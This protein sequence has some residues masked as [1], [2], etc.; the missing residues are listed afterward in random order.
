M[1]PPPS[2][3][4]G[5][6]STPPEPSSPVME[7]TQTLDV[8]FNRRTSI[9]ASGEQMLPCGFNELG[10][11]QVIVCNRLPIRLYVYCVPQRIGCAGQIG[12]AREEE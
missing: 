9:C 12:E 5:P 4:F 3:V 1:S 2:L 6:G 11:T 7:G 10:I 8:W